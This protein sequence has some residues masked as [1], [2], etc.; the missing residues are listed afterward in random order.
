MY[1]R[2]MTD[3]AGNLTSAA[4]NDRIQALAPLAQRLDELR[5]AHQRALRDITS[6]V[7]LGGAPPGALALPDAHGS[8]PVV[9]VVRRY[10]TGVEMR[11]LLLDDAAMAL[12]DS[13]R[14]VRVVTSSAVRVPPT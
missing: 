8:R 3:A 2:G 5:E 14:G 12:R 7:T 1:D 6:I 4:R 11:R 13:Q 9:F 10:T